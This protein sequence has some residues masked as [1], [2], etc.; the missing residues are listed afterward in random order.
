[1][2]AGVESV[3]ESA[4]SIE[5]AG[6]K[7]A[8][9]VMAPATVLVGDNVTISYRGETGL[10]PLIDIVNSKGDVIVSNAPMEESADNPGLYEYK[11]SNIKASDFPVGKPFTIM[12]RADV[13]LKDGSIVTNLETGSV[14]VESTSL[15]TLEGLVASTLGVKNIAKDALDAIKFV[16]GTLATGGNVDLALQYLREQVDDLPRRVAEEGLTVEMRGAVDE[17]SEKMTTLVGETGLD[18]TG[19]ME[20]GLSQ[21]PTIKE[22]RSKADDTMGTVDLLQM[23]FQQKLGGKDDPVVQVI[24]E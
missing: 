22:I 10:D 14:Q 8:G 4:V 13:T 3:L 9:E 12:T 18:F 7:Y 1:L 23:L 20:V 2:N 6:L 5:A 24:F 17:I 16:E 11:L 21:S 19:L 15:T